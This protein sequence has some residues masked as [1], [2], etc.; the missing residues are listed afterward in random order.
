MA[1]LSHAPITHSIVSRSQDNVEQMF[2]NDKRAFGS[3]MVAS[4]IV[5]LCHVLGMF[6]SRDNVGVPFF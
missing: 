3:G 6:T 4:F 5:L 1:A 2:R